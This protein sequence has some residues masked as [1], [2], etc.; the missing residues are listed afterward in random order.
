MAQKLISKVKKL[1]KK[2]YYLIKYDSSYIKAVDL[3]LNDEVKRDVL[4][5]FLISK[6]KY[7]NFLEIGCYRDDLFSKVIAEART[8]VDPVSGGNV[9]KTSDDFFRENNNEFDLIFIDGLHHYN[10]ARKDLENSL[11]CISEKGLVMLHDCLP[12]NIF[13]QSVPRVDFER[14]N[15]DVWKLIFQISENPE[16]E[17][18][19]VKIDHGIAI[20]K[21]KQYQQKTILTRSEKFE[22]LKFIYFAKNYKKKFNLISFEEFKNRF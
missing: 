13:N 3:D 20:L 22:N 10:Q 9:R 7:K 21:K 8:G 1:L 19:V 2:L 12:I 18:N 16:Y 5:N 6:K 4:V 11:N 17:L 14:W 15:G